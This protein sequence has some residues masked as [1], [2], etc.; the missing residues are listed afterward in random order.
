MIVMVLARAENGVIGR[1]GALPWHIPADL[2]RFKA[3]TMGK[4]MVMGRKTFESFPAPLPGRRHIVL[5][6]D[7]AWRAAGAEVAHD[8]EAALALVGGG[9]VAVIGGA[10]VFAL[11]E[12]RAD[13]IELTEVHGAPEGDAVV[14]PFTGWREVAREDHGAEGD[15]PAYSYVTLVRG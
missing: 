8:V 13:R 11:F 15:R 5:T 3:L 10:E 1:D 4:P 9:E 6:R 2:K 12:A 14:P 7:P